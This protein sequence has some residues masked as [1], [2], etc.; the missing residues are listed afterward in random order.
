MMLWVKRKNPVKLAVILHPEDLQG[1][2]YIVGNTGD[3]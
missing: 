3:N 1:A 2:Q